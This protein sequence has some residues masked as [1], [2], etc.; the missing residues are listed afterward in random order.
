MQYECP[1]CRALSKYNR[2]PKCGTDTYPVDEEVSGGY[3]IFNHAQ[4]GHKPCKVCGAE[5]GHYANCP[6]TRSRYRGD[7]E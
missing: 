2:C 3:T 7:R 4:N 6:E 5:F 1:N